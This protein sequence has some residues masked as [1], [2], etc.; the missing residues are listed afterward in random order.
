MKFP[1]KLKLSSLLYNKKFTA[2]LSVVL[3]FALWLG[4][5]MT[6][7]P[8]RQQTFTDL[9]A[10]VSLEGTAAADLG[11]GIVSDISSQKFSITVSGPN[12]LISSLKP[13]DFSLSASTASIN[14]ADEY[15]LDVSA[16][17]KIN[18]PE[19]KIKSVSPST[20][21]LKVDFIDTATFEGE[22]F[23]AKLI[24]VSPSDGLVAETPIISDLQQRAITIKGPRSTMEKIAS[25]AAYKEVNQTLSTSTTFDANVI[26]YDSNDKIIYRYAD[27][28]TVYDANNNIITNSFLTLSFANVKVTQPI[29]KK[30]TVTCKA[31]FSNLPS[32]ATADN[33]KYTLS[34]KN[35]TII[36]TPEIVDK[37]DS[38]TLSPIDIREVSK[39]SNSFEVS[40]VLPDGVRLFDNI[41]YFTVDID[42]SKYVETSF[43]IKNIRCKG[44]DDN[45]KAKTGKSVW[46]K[47]CAPQ[48]VMKNIQ[49]TDLYAVID[50]TDKTAG[51]YAV[52][53]DVKSD[54]YDNFWQIGK[55][56]A[57]VTIY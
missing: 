34:K 35:V 44:L 29:S 30:K 46:V 49:A 39:K 54:I 57:S 32:T 31:T 8:I 3:A 4:I 9:S 51:E 7:N 28:G 33:I 53:V 45:L 15:T 11:L 23:V 12:Y 19:L 40:A 22:K 43:E 48:S 26:L 27:D 42:V 41:E 55:Y 14:T 16:T 17:T 2:I 36:G 20:V 6:E 47:I 38:I 24:G 21:N 1:Q 52:G 37:I 13:E 50:L 5:A 18:D 25:V 10:S 56:S